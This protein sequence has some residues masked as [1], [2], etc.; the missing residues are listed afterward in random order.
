MGTNKKIYQMILSFGI[1]GKI[2]SCPEGCRCIIKFHTDRKFLDMTTDEL[3]NMSSLIQNN[4]KTL[5]LLGNNLTFFPVNNLSHLVNLEHLIL[6]Y[7]SL[8][9]VPE[10]LSK[11][12]P[13][14]ETLLLTGNHISDLTTLNGL[15]NI[16]TLD[17]DK[18]VLTKIPNNTFSN[19]D[20]LDKLSIQ[21]N[22]ITSLGEDS[23]NGLSKLKSLYL[24][25]NGIEFVHAQAFEDFKKLE[26][27]HLQSNK[28]KQL[29][30]QTFGKQ[31]KLK[32]LYLY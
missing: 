9:T 26:V 19:F 8:K 23:L 30:L 12:F 29:S 17:L 18:N 11:F 4:T 7:N 21:T 10:D 5:N 3:K 22:K 20:N 24:N 2:I 31:E 28:L 1:F 25:G 13:K 32:T 15:Q 16:K 6:S 14:L 27:F